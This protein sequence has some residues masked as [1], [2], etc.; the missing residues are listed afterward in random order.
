MNQRAV[1]ILAAAIV[2]AALIIALAPV[3]VTLA[4]QILWPTPRFAP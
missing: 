1:Y 4:R 2:L 3:L